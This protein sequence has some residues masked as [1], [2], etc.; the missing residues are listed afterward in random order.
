MWE[1]DLGFF[2]IFIILALV[3][4]DM[5][6]LRNFN[7]TESWA[8]KIGTGELYHNG[9]SLNPVM[10][11]DGR[12]ARARNGAVIGVLLDMNTLTIQ[13]FL[14]GVAATPNTINELKG[15]KVCFRVAE[16]DF[17]KRSVSGHFYDRYS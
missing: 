8:L 10:L 3:K 7:L 16:W 15:T 17:R 4:V 14:D 11:L 9:R 2:Q 1:L 5:P 12:S 13:F 6:K